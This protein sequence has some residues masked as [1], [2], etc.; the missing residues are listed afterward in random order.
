MNRVNKCFGVGLLFFSSMCLK[1][2]EVTFTNTTN[3]E[4]VVVPTGVEPGGKITALVPPRGLS[5][6][7]TMPGGV[8]NVQFYAKKGGKYELL[9]PGQN[10]VMFSKGGYLVAWHPAVKHNKAF[11]TSP[12]HANRFEYGSAFRKGVHDKGNKQQVS[13]L[14]G[15]EPHLIRIMKLN[16]KNVYN[17]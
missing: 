16:P 13:K 3:Q 14:Y 9:N 4:I 1:A 12:A 8:R 17:K 11:Y 10:F 2:H 6:R 7:F 5:V 15:K